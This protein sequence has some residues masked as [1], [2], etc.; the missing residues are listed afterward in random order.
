[1]ATAITHVLTWLRGEQVGKDSEGN[2]YYQERRIPKVGRRR[3]LVIYNGGDEA[4]RIPPEW[5]AW[6]HYTVD[7]TPDPN[8]VTVKPWQQDHL[9]NLTGTYEAY[10]PPGHTLEGGRRS[11]ATGDYEPWTPN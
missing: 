10:R 6:L 11:A 9:P 1:M 8:K 4:S 7:Y 2:V 3:R 5:H